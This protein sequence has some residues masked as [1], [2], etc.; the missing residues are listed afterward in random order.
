MEVFLESKNIQ[1]EKKNDSISNN[2][3]KQVEK[4]LLEKE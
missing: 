4:I 1:E 3:I 2:K